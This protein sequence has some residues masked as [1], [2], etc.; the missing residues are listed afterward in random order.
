MA[1]GVDFHAEAR[2]IRSTTFNPPSNLKRGSVK[3]EDGINSRES[4]QPGLVEGLR[5]ASNR[6]NLQSEPAREGLNLSG[7]SCL[8]RLCIFRV[9]AVP[10]GIRLSTLSPIF[11]PFVRLTRVCRDGVTFCNHLIDVYFLVSVVCALGY[12]VCSLSTDIF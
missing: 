2:K 6:I 10:A 12:G 5:G 8:P 11:L 3:R 1:E 9:H 4:R 7:C